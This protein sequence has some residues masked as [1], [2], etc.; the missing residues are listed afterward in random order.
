MRHG[1]GD[2]F[3]KMIKLVE[4]YKSSKVNIYHL[5]NKSHFNHIQFNGGNP[6]CTYC[7]CVSSNFLIYDEGVGYCSFYL[8]AYSKPSAAY[9]LK[10]IDGRYC[11]NII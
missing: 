2:V 4:I 3:I 7:V 1:Q 11:N 9:I 10:V 6:I 5:Q 8:H